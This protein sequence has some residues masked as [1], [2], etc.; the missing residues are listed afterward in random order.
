MRILLSL[1][2][3]VLVPVAA[4][5]QAPVSY[6]IRNET[7]AMNEDGT[8]LEWKAYPPG[9]GETTKLEAGEN[10][11]LTISDAHD[12]AGVGVGQWIKIEPGYKYRATLETEGEGG[13]L[14][15]LSFV[16]RIPAKIG[17]MNQIKMGE[18]KSWVAAGQSGALEGIAPA[19]A[20]Y[21]WVWI[22]SPSK[23]ESNARVLVKS[24]K[25]EELGAVPADQVPAAATP[26][27]KKGQAAE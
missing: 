10:G 5:A 27:P 18:V 13:L 26:A 12:T 23:T 6:E 11:G 22:Y 7:F 9:N 1:L 3:T 19:E 15:S 24:V 20:I 16:P 17:Q 21:A 2:L 25:V 8:P 4:R 14:F